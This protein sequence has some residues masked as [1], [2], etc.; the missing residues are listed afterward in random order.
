MYL[1]RYSF[2]G[3]R[4][5]DKLL[6]HEEILQLSYYSNGAI[7]QD[8][9]YSLPIYLRKFYLFKIGQYIQNQQ[10]SST[11]DHSASETTQQGLINAR[12]VHKNKK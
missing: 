3:L 6:V 5:E 9:A 12:M 2:F 7:T 8:I 4:T 1:L 11:N 10:K